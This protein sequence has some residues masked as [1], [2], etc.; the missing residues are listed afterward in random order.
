MNLLIMLANVLHS[1]FETPFRDYFFLLF[2]LIELN[3]EKK[4]Q[5]Q[6]VTHVFAHLNLKFFYLRSTKCDPFS[7]HVTYV[8]H[9]NV[10]LQF[11][12]LRPFTSCVCLQFY[13]LLHF[14][15]EK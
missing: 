3:V 10:C 11:S 7:S 5:Q 6:H 4:Q 1:Y 15:N 13:F 2:E 9:F 12:L 8:R 14:K